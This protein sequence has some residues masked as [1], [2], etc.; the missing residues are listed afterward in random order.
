[1]KESAGDALLRVTKDSNTYKR[2]LKG[3][4]VQVSFLVC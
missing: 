1:M 2:I 3:L 4:I